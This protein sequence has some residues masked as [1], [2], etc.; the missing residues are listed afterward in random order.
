MERIFGPSKDQGR[1]PEGSARTNRGRHQESN[2]EHEVVQSN[3]LSS[4]VS[5][6]SEKPFHG[7]RSSTTAR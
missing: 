3:T 5:P 4:R 1:P 7:V 2:R 6:Q